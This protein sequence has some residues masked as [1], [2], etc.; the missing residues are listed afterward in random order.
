[1][2]LVSSKKKESDKYKTLENLK[3]EIV[4]WRKKGKKTV[5]CHGVFDLLHIGHI[6]HFQQAKGFGDLLIVTLTPDVYV[7]KGPNRPAFNQDLRADALCSLQCVDYVSINQWPIAEKL[8]ELLQPD[9]YVKGKD[10]KD[11][12]VNKKD[13]GILKENQAICSV[14]GKMLFTNEPCF[15]S[16]TLINRHL[17]QQSPEMK[18]FFKE[19]SKRYCFEDIKNFL[20]SIAS[21]KV[22]LVGESI[23]DDYHF[24][25]TLGKSGKDP[26]LAVSYEKKKTYIGG[27]LAVANHMAH[28]CNH[29]HV[30]TFSGKNCP[31]LPL[32]HQQTH[33]S[34]RLQILEKHKHQTLVKRRFFEEYPV[35]K[36]FEI[37][38]SNP[39]E[40]DDKDIENL[41]Q[42]LAEQISYFDM[43][44]VTDYGH[45]MIQKPIIELLCQRAPFLALNTQVNAGNLAYNTVEKYPRADFVCIAENEIRLNAKDKKT[46]IKKL[47]IDLSQR[48]QL[49]DI[50]VTR[51]KRGIICHRSGEEFYNVPAFQGKTLDRVGAGDSVLAIASLLVKK[52]V[53]MELIGLMS[54]AVGFQ[55][56]QVIGNGASLDK[57][58]L[59][60]TLE[61]GMKR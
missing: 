33:P 26:I 47:C 3:K 22:L 40:D 9:V 6:R 13:P 38:L 41:K 49:S 28:I 2:S 34:L 15:S 45:G 46:E 53:P 43:V 29:V 32:I 14:G 12:L 7:N 17:P 42:A 55:T 16:S 1:M 25:K 59:L 30:L 54:N 31:Y 5:L 61:Y 11:L 51:G 52:R 20:D 4:L 50:M 23:I 44:V 56:T 48:M 39:E 24:C 60:R 37:Y 21:L 18:A 19:V 58:M 8:I 57:E 36:L 10:Y 27:V 35:Q